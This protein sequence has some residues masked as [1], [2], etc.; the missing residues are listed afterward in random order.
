MLMPFSQIAS[1]IQEVLFPAFSRL[2]DDADRIAAVWLRVNRAV[3]ALTIPGLLGLIAVA[4]DFVHVVLGDRWRAAV[5]VMQILSWVGL[6]QSLQRFNSSILEARNRTGILL[7]YAA[8]ALAAS[9][10]AFVFGL[11]YGIVGVAAG[12]AI[13]CT[14]VEP[15]Y[16]WLTGREIGVSL[17][18]FAHTLAGVFAASLVMFLTVLGARMLL[19]AH[20]TAAGVRLPVLIA[21]GI[22]VYV[23]L[24]ALFE[25]ELVGE[26]RRLRPGGARSAARLQATLRH[27]AEPLL[28]A[29]APADGA[30]GDLR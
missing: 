4:P 8:V 30:V 9:V 6:L 28:L 26:A 20:G 14:F 11:R 29:D 13:A 21:L 7:G 1:P 27:R 18:R 22:A 19:V 2:Q 12:Y 16:A 24:C 23:P 15:F 25:P 17:K 10:A 3:G 5:P